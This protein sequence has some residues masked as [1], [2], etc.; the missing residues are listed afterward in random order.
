VDRASPDATGGR[1][2][3]L[4]RRR[5]RRHP[6]RHPADRREHAA[7]AN[8]NWDVDIIELYDPTVNDEPVT[9]RIV[10]ML[11]RAANGDAILNERSSAGEDFSAFLA[12]R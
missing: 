6:S 11:E 4:R 9:A 3:D 7:S 2:P 1:A 12:E 8:A 5:A 10:R